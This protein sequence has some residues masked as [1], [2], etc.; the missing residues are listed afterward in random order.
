MLKNLRLNDIRNRLLFRIA[1]VDLNAE[2]P[3][4]SVQLCRNARDKTITPCSHMWVFFISS[5]NLILIGES[6]QEIFIRSHLLAICLEIPPHLH[7]ICFWGFFNF[8]M[9]LNPKH[10]LQFGFFRLLVIF[11]VVDILTRLIFVSSSWCE[12]KH[13]CLGVGKTYCEF[14]LHAAQNTKQYVPGEN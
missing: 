2:V 11:S 12:Q 1:E 3:S 10:L 6:I 5:I 14:V 13:T 9:Y 7:T 8:V 4:C